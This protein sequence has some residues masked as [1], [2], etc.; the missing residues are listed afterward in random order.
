MPRM[1]G[2]EFTRRYRMREEG[3][4]HLPIYALT[5]NTAEDAMALCMEAGMDGFL[6]K[7][8]EPEQLEAIIE[9]FAYSRT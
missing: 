6:N 2:I 5:A 1:D 3:D 4:R 7:P 8:I 9:R